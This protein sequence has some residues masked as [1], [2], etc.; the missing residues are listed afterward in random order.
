MTTETKTTLVAVKDLKV[1]M[2][3]DWQSDKYADP[4][5]NDTLFEN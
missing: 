2:I 4:D 5:S 1:G 3:M